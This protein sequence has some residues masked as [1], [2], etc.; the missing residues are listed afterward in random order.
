MGYIP[1]IYPFD[2]PRISWSSTQPTRPDST[3]WLVFALGPGVAKFMW[4]KT[5]SKDVVRLQFWIPNYSHLSQSGRD[6]HFIQPWV[7][8]GCADDSLAVRL[9]KTVSGPFPDQTERTMDSV[10]SHCFSYLGGG[11]GR[12]GRNRTLP[13]VLPKAWSWMWMQFGKW[14]NT[15]V[16]TLR[17][18]PHLQLRSLFLFQHLSNI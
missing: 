18:S 4:R 13:S 12:R 16:G 9:E 8:G 17:V 10:A 5:S 15:I 11:R 6:F 2:L 7:R 14:W 3:F 1:L